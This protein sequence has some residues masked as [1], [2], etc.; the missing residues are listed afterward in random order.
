M[1]IRYY[2]IKLFSKILVDNKMLLLYFSI[3]HVINRLYFLLKVDPKINIDFFRY[4]SSIFFLS[5]EVN[6]CVFF[7]FSEGFGVINILLLF[8]SSS[9]IFEASYLFKYILQYNII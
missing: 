8:P 7:S 4:F 2:M 9:K 3:I 5:L 6:I 1:Q